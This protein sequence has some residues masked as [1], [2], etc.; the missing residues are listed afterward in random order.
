MLLD[1]AEQNGW[2]PSPFQRGGCRSWW[3]A[4]REEARAL[5]EDRDGLQLLR[6]ELLFDGV[7]SCNL[8]FEL[9][10]GIVDLNAL[11]I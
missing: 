4:C 6:R 7:E 8:C 3:R 9:W 1:A 11:T 2:T 10:S 5:R